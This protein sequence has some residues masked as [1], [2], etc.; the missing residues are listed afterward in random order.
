[1]SRRIKINQSTQSTHHQQ[2]TITSN[3]K[4]SSS[5]ISRR[6]KKQSSTSTPTQQIIITSNPKGQIIQNSAHHKYAGG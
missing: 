5:T 3:T 2:I 6:I 1:V 4:L